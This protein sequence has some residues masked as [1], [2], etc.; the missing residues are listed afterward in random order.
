[1]DMNAKRA[2]VVGGGSGIGEATCRLMTER[3]ARVAVVDI[4]PDRAARVA[5]TLDGAIAVECDARDSRQVD[6]CIARVVAELGGV[7]FL[8]NSVSPPGDA[9]KQNALATLG[10]VSEEEGYL[11]PSVPT[12]ST[13]IDMS[14]EAWD[15]EM[16]SVLYPVFYFTRAALRVM[17]PQR[18]GSIVSL[19]S[20]H[21]VAGFP[22]FPHYSAAKAGIVGFTRAAAREVGPHNI[23]VN[24]IPSGYALTPHSAHMMPE[25]FKNST[26][27]MTPLG[28]L[29][30]ADEIARVVCFLC[31]DESSFLTGQAVSVNGGFLTV[32]S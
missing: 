3:G 29:G 4:D 25:A 1:M 20:I 28:R 17:I 24:A 9:A 12:F 11:V 16:R 14:D 8:V 32:P 23:R 10:R 30:E 21:A 15:T 7:D 19:A 13:I 22:G 31:S 5:G 2:V 18:Y 6:A 27:R 26:A